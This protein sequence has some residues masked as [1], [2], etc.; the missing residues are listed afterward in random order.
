M[1]TLMTDDITDDGTIFIGDTEA[2][3]VFY[4][5][6]LTEE[7]GPLVAEGCIS[8][9]EEFMNRIARSQQVRLQLE[10]GPTF[11]LITDGGATGSR[12]VRLFK[13]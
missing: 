1:R 9:S 12:W 3:K 11:A 2:G 13:I 7:V 4:W 5:L 10:N 8:G 6:T